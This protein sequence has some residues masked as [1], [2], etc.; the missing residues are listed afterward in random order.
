MAAR[1]RAKCGILLPRA[2]ASNAQRFALG[3]WPCAGHGRTPCA[4]WR[5]GPTSFTRK[6]TLQTVGGGRSSFRSTTGIKTPSSACT[7]RTNSAR[8]ETPQRGGRNKSGE[9]AAL[10]GGRR[11]REAWRGGG[12]RNLRDG[13]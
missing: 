10:G 1:R 6:P 11:W 5:L 3:C 9:G 12:G 13:G 8:T 7:R 4:A 2:C